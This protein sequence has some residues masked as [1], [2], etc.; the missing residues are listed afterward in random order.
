MSLQNSKQPFR[1]STPGLY[2][3]LAGYYDTLRD[4]VGLSSPQFYQDLITERTR[5]I[6]ELG[7]GTGVVTIALADR[8]MEQRGSL[9]GT[10]IVGLDVAAEMF[11]IARRRDSR[12]E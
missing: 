11:Q 7:C 12:I 6:L 8:L 2:G 10:R 1:D 4:I 5:S 3:S 9:A